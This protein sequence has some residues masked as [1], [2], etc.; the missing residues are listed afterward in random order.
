M[1]AIEDYKFGTGVAGSAEDFAAVTPSDGTDLTFRCR[2]LFI[3]TAGNVSALAADGST[4]VVFKNLPS[5]SVLPI[6][7]SRV[8]ATGTT[9]TDIVALR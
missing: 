8:R 2:A 4:V 1:P 3:G 6:R 7:T 9:A 5:G